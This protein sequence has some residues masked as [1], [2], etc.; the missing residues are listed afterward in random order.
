MANIDNIEYV[1]RNR[2]FYKFKQFWRLN[3]RIIVLLLLLLI[4]L[5]F[6]WWSNNQVDENF[7]NVFQ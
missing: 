2:K 4:S 3:W 5:A 7:T 6:I 1:V